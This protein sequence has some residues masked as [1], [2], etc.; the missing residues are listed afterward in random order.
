MTKECIAQ[1][2]EA[3]G[4]SAGKDGRF[5]LPENREAVCLVATPADVLPVERLI[6]IELRAQFVA[7]ENAKHERFF[8]TYDNILGLRMLAGPA[9]RERVAGFGR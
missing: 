3:E 2:L 6:A 8:F 1:V 9:A 7:L 5:T 4:L